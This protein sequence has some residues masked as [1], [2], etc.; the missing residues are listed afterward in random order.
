M[1]TDQGRLKTEETL[2]NETDLLEEVVDDLGLLDWES[3][4][5]DVL[6]ALDLSVY[7][8]LH[9]HEGRNIPQVKICTNLE[10]DGQAWSRG[11]TSPLAHHRVHDHVHVRARRH[12]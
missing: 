1:N 4:E 10:R 3:M 9:R 5:V 11:P 12:V 6:D 7:K 2:F 8:K